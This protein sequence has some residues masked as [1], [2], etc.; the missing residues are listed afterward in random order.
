MMRR[1]KA[2]LTASLSSCF[3]ACLLVSCG[4]PSATEPSLETHQASEA[5]ADASS[6]LDEGA[7]DAAEGAVRFTDILAQYQALNARLDRVAARLQLA[8]AE[9]CPVT[10]RSP[11]YKVHTLSDY[12]AQLRPVAA[13]LLDVDERLSVR[14]V[15]GGGPAEAAGLRPGDKLRAIKGQ[16]LASGPTQ[17]MFYDRVSATAFEGET[18]VLTVLRG[19]RALT[20]TI[21]P[22]TLCGY[23]ALVVYDEAINGRTDGRE[24]FITSALMRTVQNDVH[25]ALIVAHE[26]AH[27]IEGHLQLSPI[28]A[29]RK[30]L[31]LR[32]DSMALVMLARAGFNIDEAVAYWTRADNPQRQSQSRSETH[33]SITE[34][35]ENFESVQ[36]AVRQAKLRGETLGGEALDFS[37]IP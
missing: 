27:A 2:V 23:P 26:M 21:A 13:A 3:S 5:E 9:L 25:L 1:A 29:E 22:Q 11:G 33:P 20:L 31:E 32:A 36:R 7:E 17:H 35:L 16:P 12:P 14:A 34:R 15:R 8:S 18:A 30:A 4:A 19:E 6:V 10:I 37:I 28:D 24:V